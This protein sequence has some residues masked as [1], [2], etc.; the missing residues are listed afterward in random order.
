MENGIL[1]HKD[2]D[3]DALMDIPHFMRRSS[4]KRLLLEFKKKQEEKDVEALW[5]DHN[6]IYAYKKRAKRES[7]NNIPF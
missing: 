7:Y 5:D 3:K 1:F 6:M 4:Q 2:Y